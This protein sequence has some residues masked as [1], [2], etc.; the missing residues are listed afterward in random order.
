M[1]LGLSYGELFVTLGVISVILG[2]LC[3]VSMQVVACSQPE[4]GARAQQACRKALRCL[5]GTLVLLVELVI[6]A[7]AVRACQC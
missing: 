3:L 6:K 2:A 1:V 4:G 7:Q 5:C